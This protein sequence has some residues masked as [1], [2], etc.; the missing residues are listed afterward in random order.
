MRTQSVSASL[1]QPIIDYKNGQ[2][3]INGITVQLSDQERAF[4]AQ[5][6]LNA[7]RHCEKGWLLEQVWAH[8]SDRPPRDRAADTIACKANKAFR[9]AV[10]G[11]EAIVKS[12]WSRG[13]LIFDSQVG[14]IRELIPDEARVGPAVELFTVSGY[15]VAYRN[16]CVWINDTPIKLTTQQTELL[17][18]LLRNQGRMLE[19]IELIEH[20]HP[21]AAV[22]GTPELKLIDVLVCYI[23][24]SIESAGIN[25]PI[26]DTVWGQGYIVS[27]SE[28]ASPA[29]WPSDL[30]PIDTRWVSSR[31]FQLASLV[32]SN[33]RTAREI[34]GYYPGLTSEHIERWVELVK[35]YGAPGLRST[36]AQNYAAAA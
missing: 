33:R 30:P 19:K 24:K 7:G 6:L 3:L 15:N 9:A 18:H 34:A 5:L 25:R 14:D 16:C 2:V 8:R 22:S 27:T 31:K 29:A 32:L 26:I 20:L 1:D 23:R 28:T 4:V 11:I 12:V 21:G 36:R 35:K 10:P 17:L 13:Y